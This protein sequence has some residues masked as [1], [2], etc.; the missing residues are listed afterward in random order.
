MEKYMKVIYEK[1]IDDF[2]YRN[3]NGCKTPLRCGAHLHYHVEIVYMK[4]GVAKVYID[5]DAYEI[6]TGDLL[7]VFPNKIHRFE[8]ISNENRYELFIINPDLVPELSQKITTENPLDPIIRDVS[9][10]PRIISLISIL[11]TSQGFPASCK[12]YLMKGYLLSFFAEILEMTPMKNGKADEHQ[13][14][15]AV[16]QYCSQNFT[17]DLSLSILEEELHLSK[18]YISHLFGDNLGI[19]F[20]DYVN[21]LRIS[22]ACRL[23]R[24]TDMSITEISNTS[25]FGTLRTFNR[26]F[27]KQMG[28]SPSEY[29]RSRRDDT[30]FASIPQQH[31]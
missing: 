17:K 8:D 15:R 31:R 9:K 27:I 19:C 20:N 2:Y 10:N 11:A 4:K 24:T 7:F 26:A 13:A 29:K 21:S 5:S 25:G 3:D 22:E 16:V 6:S 12:D 18:Y 14:M 23:L 28:M 30:S 1:K